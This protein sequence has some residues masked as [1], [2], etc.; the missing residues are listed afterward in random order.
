MELR[1]GNV[2]Y[3]HRGCSIFVRE[4]NTKTC[5]YLMIE[6]NLDQLMFPIDTVLV[7]DFEEKLCQVVERLRRVCRKRILKVNEIRSK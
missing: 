4:V 6:Y 2:L 7:V 3:C 1:Q 5:I